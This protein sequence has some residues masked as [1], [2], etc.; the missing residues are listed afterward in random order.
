MFTLASLEKA[1]DAMLWPR[2]V[3]W[4]V[5]GDGVRHQPIPP[6]RRSREE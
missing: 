2:H 4:P 1:L 5:D 3:E 6:H